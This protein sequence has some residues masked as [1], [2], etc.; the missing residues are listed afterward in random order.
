MKTCIQCLI[1]RKVSHSL[2]D[3]LC[4]DWSQRSHLRVNYDSINHFNCFTRYL[5]NKWIVS[6][7]KSITH[8]IRFNVFEAH[9]LPLITGSPPPAVWWTKSDGSPLESVPGLRQL[10]T[11]SLS[12]QL[13][14]LPFSAN[15]YRQDIHSTQVRCVANNTV[16]VIVSS[17]CH[18]RAS[19]W[20]IL[21]S[22]NLYFFIHNVWYSGEIW[23][24]LVKTRLL[25]M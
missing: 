17:D 3:I 7:L 10:T 5:W 24:R 9:I 13:V 11:D 2:K 4:S 1:V 20:T 16:G 6:L 23:D 18:I 15:Q 14:Y 12:T 19:K 21:S 25:W 22:F 8:I